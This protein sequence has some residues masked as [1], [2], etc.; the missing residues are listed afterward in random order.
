MAHKR[1]VPRTALTRAEIEGMSDEDLAAR[2]SP[3]EM[4]DITA[5]TRASFDRTPLKK[6][7]DES[8][9]QFRQRTRQA[10]TIDEVEFARSARQNAEAWLYNSKAQKQNRMKDMLS[11]TV[12]PESIAARKKADAERAKRDQERDRLSELSAVPYPPGV[13]GPSVEWEGKDK[14]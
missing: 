4:K 5:L 10:Q 2:L 7:P 6:K 9:G 8:T 14:K 3:R 11:S 1:A 13:A 12:T